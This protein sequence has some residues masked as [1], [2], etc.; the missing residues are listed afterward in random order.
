MESKPLKG[1]EYSLNYR[2]TLKTADRPEIHVETTHFSCAIHQWVCNVGQ[3]A[4]N[5]KLIEPAGP[6]GFTE[7]RRESALQGVI[8]GTGVLVRWRAS[9]CGI[10]YIQHIVRISFTTADDFCTQRR[11]FTIGDGDNGQ[12]PDFQ[13]THSIVRRYTHTSNEV[14]AVLI[15]LDNVVEAACGDTGKEP[16]S[17]IGFCCGFLAELSTYDIVVSCFYE[18]VNVPAYASASFL[19]DA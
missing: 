16:G 15:Q 12:A 17:G 3:R 7:T 19:S 6:K 11:A 9:E 5:Q 13:P 8:G 4:V 1:I 18:R 14:S 2:P 10:E